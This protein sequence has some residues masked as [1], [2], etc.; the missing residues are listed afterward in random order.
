MRFTSAARMLGAA[1]LLAPAIVGAQSSATL[2][3]VTDQN[4]SIS[5]QSLVSAAGNINTDPRYQTPVSPA[6]NGVGY[7]QMTSNLGTFACTGSLLEDGKSV[8][9]A[10][11]CLK[12]GVGNVTSILV[13][14]YD[15]NG[16]FRVLSASGWD[17]HPLYSTKVMDEND[18]GVVHLTAEAPSTISRYKIFT[19]DATDRAF[20]F[21]GFG[22]RGSFG[23]GVSANGNFQLASRKQ[24]ENLFDLYAGDSRFTCPVGSP[25]CAPGSNF[26]NNVFGSSAG[27][28][29]HVLLTDFDSGLA[30][31]NGMCV[32]G[33][34]TGD[35]NLGNSE[36][37]DGYG[38]NEAISGQGDSGGP[39]FINGMIAS[40]TSFGATF[41][42]GVSDNDN[43]L[44]SSFGEFAGFTDVAYHA[45]WIQSEMDLG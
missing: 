34:F 41:G 14:F 28:V 22:Q 37:Q 26:W 2:V 45:S 21:V 12:G 7:V 6:Y 33:Q 11:H 25:F 29:G 18:I 27:N 36:C 32:L 10:A 31:N 5:L 4:F 8:L 42:S 35:T 15:S 1:L 17:A 16:A 24:G 39:G 20:E 30:A 19:G 43:A 40:V 23:A 38:L 44:N 3:S 13:A 9:T